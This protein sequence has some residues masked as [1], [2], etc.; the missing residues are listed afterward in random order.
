M[1]VQQ[2]RVQR[3]PTRRLHQ[4]ARIEK[5]WSVPS[6]VSGRRRY[7]QLHGSGEIF[8]FKMVFHSKLNDIFQFN[9]I[10]VCRKLQKNNLKQKLF[11]CSVTSPTEAAA[12]WPF[13]SRQAAPFNAFANLATAEM[14][15]DRSD[16]SPVRPGAAML[17]LSCPLETVEGLSCPLVLPVL[18]KMA[19]LVFRWQLLSFAI[20]SLVTPVRKSYK[21][22]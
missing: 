5:M 12:R 4:C 15:L 3:L 22:C 16:A 17:D 1:P 19:P 20:A 7:V 13:A 2:R 9:A 8:Y 18:A 11:C 14:E 10:S 6:R 21:L